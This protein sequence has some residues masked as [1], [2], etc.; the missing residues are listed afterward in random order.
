M[1]VRALE[2]I[3]RLSSFR[4]DVKWVAQDALHWTLQFLGDL[5]DDELAQVCRR[6]ASAVRGHAPFPLVAH[7]IGAFPAVA[8]PRTLWLGAGEG[9][10]ALCRLQ[11]A[12]EKALSDLGFRGE[13]R[14]FVPHLTLG[15]VGRGGAGRQRLVERLTELADFTGESML[16]EEVTVQASY[17]QRSGPTY[18]VLARAPLQGAN[19]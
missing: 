17:L 10:D 7:G 19:C 16:V 8:R 15:R 1:Q 6:V 2:A 9:G 5:D 13:R 12:G 18:Q 4:A 3:D 11:S 14:P